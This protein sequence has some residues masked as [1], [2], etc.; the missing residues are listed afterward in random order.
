MTIKGVHG[1][2]D[3]WMPQDLI[4]FII[5]DVFVYVYGRASVL[6]LSYGN[7]QPK[8]RTR[9]YVSISDGSS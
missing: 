9:T 8:T 3:A 4:I 7:K 1:C 5:C 2:V 6:P